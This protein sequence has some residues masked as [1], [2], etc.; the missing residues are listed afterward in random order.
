MDVAWS[1]GSGEP[2]GEGFATVYAS[3][4]YALFSRRLAKLALSLIAAHGA[5]GRELLDLACGAGAGTV[6]FAEADYSATGIDRSVTMLTH[7]QRRAEAMGLEIRLFQQEVQT[8][9]LPYRVDVVTCLF[10]SLNYLLRPEEL[11]AVFSRVAAVLRPGGLFVFDMNTVHGLATR[12]GT[13]DCVSTARR[14]VMEVNRYRFEANECI[15]TI[16]T[17]AFVR[18][19][20]GGQFRR[21]E[22]VH[23]ERGYPVATVRNLVERAGLRVVKVHGLYDRFQGL[24]GLQ[25]LTEDSGRMV[26]VARRNAV[27]DDCTERSVDLRG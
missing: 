19:D 3:E 7:A 9:C 2:Y 27:E 8:V 26:V 22:E 6:V 15:S 25:P 10:D 17:T 24:S 11:S 20:E 5:P 14:D 21:F 16:R 23:R 18:Q 13:R 1:A 4:R 12:W